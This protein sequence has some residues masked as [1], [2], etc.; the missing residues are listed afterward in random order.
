MAEEKDPKK[1]Q[2]Q[3][4]EKPKKA[5]GPTEM[6]LPVLLGIIGGVLVIFMAFIYFL[7]LP[8]LVDGI[9]GNTED[10]TAGTEQME[11]SEEGSHDGDEKEKGDGMSEE[12]EYLAGD[13]G[14][15]FVETGK[16]MTNPKGSANKIVVLNLGLE[17]RTKG[18][19]EEESHGEGE[20][21]SIKMMAKIKGIVNTT[22]GQWT[23]EDLDTKRDSIASY[24]KDGMKPLFKKNDM[25][26]RDVIL[27]E[28]II[29]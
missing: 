10:N 29:Q 27:Q 14:L 11:T 19:E 26:L 8:A 17:F 20:L 5:K 3:K 1:E 6:S 21:I 22:I 2:K 23:I 16:L 13:E 4:P 9:S 12:D 18:D 15:H 7:V 28:Y 24:L 25:F